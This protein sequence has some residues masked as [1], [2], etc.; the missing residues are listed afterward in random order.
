MSE[1]IK[2]IE[3]AVSESVPVNAMVTKVQLHASDVVIYTKNMRL[4][5]ESDVLVKSLAGKLKK[6]VHARSDTSLLKDPEESKA[7]IQKLVP[8]DAGIQDINFDSEFN[9]VVIEARKPGL[10]I[11]KHGSTLKAIT[12][13]TGWYPN[14]L[15]TPSKPS[16][17][18]RGIRY[19]LLKENKERAKMLKEIGARIYR[20]PVK[21]TDWIRLTPLGGAR[22]VGR[23]CYIIE[24]PESKVMLD[25]GV[26]VASR[27]RPYPLL[28]SINWT[29][30]DLDAVILSHAH[31]DHC[32]F[33]P[34]LYMF[35]Y[36]GPVY[37]TAPTRDIAT[38]LMLDYIEVTMKE[39]RD[40]PY[41]QKEIKEFVKHTIT[42]EYGEVTD[43]AP[44]VRL[45]LHNAG[46]ILGS[47]SVHLHIGQGAHNLLFTGDFKFG[48]TKL[49]DAVHTHYPRIETLVMESTYGSP[50]DTQ[51]PRYVSDKRLIE[52]IQQTTD[53]GGSV[54][55]PVFAVGRAQEVMLV[56]E[57]YAKRNGWDIPI[58]IDGMTREASAI[59]T[60]YPE[61]L[62]R[63]VK[64]RVLHNNSPFDSEIFIEV[65]KTRRDEIASEKAS[66]IL[67]PSG[68]MTGGP[69]TEYFKQMC[70]N[71]KNSIIFVGY[72]G[73][74]SLGRKVQ[75]I[76]LRR[77]AETRRLPLHVDG[78]T[79][80]L[81][82]NLHIENIEGFSGHS[83]R[84]QLIGFYKRLM[85]KPERVICVHGDERSCISLSKTISQ[86][87]R[88]EATAPRNLDSIRLK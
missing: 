51:P 75:N 20:S 77:N 37:S 23:S 19:N 63:N 16:E 67:T 72:Q 56:L 74:G 83:D 45:T 24:T 57:E 78:K 22:E 79:K 85:P 15:R 69:S 81:E 53:Q 7:S 3:K 9:E 6:R 8:E 55:I 21:P 18:L 46:H 82:V 87:F 17:V 60:A 80:E 58:Y 33:T 49:F 25:C 1:F 73:E 41:G 12:L 14:I 40:P 13:E 62:R 34:Y 29:L 86:N 30:D 64:K 26:N 32:G 39:G 5:L 52:T 84:N 54:L 10:V 71:P 59:H 70:E 28:D 2:E 31:L 4:F 35:G 68:M 47:S 61:F 43:I 44:D 66:V 42:R 27:E 50:S 88:V 36:K 65:D 38:M 76:G 11:G 48:Y